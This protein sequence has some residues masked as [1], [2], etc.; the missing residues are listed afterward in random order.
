MGYRKISRKLREIGVKKLRGGKWNSERIADI[1]KNE[2]YIGNAL[3]QKKYVKD[4][5]NK[6]LVFNK[7]NLPQYYA[8]DTHPAIIDLDTFQRAQE[9]LSKN[10]EKYL[11]KNKGCKYPFTGKIVCGICGKKYGH[12]NSKGKGLWYCSTYLKYG[13]DSCPYKQI[14]EAILISLARDVLEIKNFD[15]AAFKEKVKEIQVPEP[16]VLIF[17]FQDGNIVK[18]EWNYNLR[19]ESWSEE[20]SQK[21]REISLNNMNGRS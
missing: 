12:K 3:L 11:V 15:E 14:P 9:I 13:K 7:G 5:L 19:R 4:H 8:E 2:K 18:K 1:I 17:V 16:N 21:A 20:A 6:T 10:R